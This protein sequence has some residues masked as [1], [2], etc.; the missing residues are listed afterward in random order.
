MIRPLGNG[1]RCDPR[2]IRSDGDPPAEH[3]GNETR[4]LRPT[5]AYPRNH[6]RDSSPPLTENAPVRQI[7]GTSADKTE[8]RRRDDEAHGR[9]ARPKLGT[10][11][12]LHAVDVCS[13]A[14]FGLW[15]LAAL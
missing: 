2:P 8:A 4:T 5:T 15:Y 6:Y 9:R 7:G 12:R 3:E 10:L 13:S 1:W 14:Q 11:E